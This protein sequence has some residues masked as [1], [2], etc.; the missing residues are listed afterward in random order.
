MEADTSTIGEA[1][2]MLERKPGGPPGRKHLRRQAV[3][4]AAEPVARRG[5]ALAA[6]PAAAVARGLTAARPT[7]ETAA[8]SL[9]V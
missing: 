4:R 9:V 3:R 5:A 2:G 1:A 8:I 7:A 6:R